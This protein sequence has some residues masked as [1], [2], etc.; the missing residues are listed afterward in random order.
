LDDDLKSLAPFIEALNKVVRD[1]SAY[2]KTS[3]EVDEQFSAELA[4]VINRSKAKTLHQTYSIK[5][6]SQSIV[7]AL[8][9]PKSVNELLLQ[10]AQRCDLSPKEIRLLKDIGLFTTD[11]DNQIIV[12]S[13]DDVLL[14]TSRAGIY[15]FLLGC[16]AG[17]AI[18]SILIEPDAGISL[19]LRGAGLGI[20]IGSIAGFVLGRSSRAYP[21]LAKLESIY[22]WLKANSAPITHA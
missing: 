13:K 19:I 1:P 11:S 17:F 15:L 5:A 22:P 18:A 14:P 3:A 7:R 12:R 2:Q 16:L 20:A 4:D 21:V 10:I 8:H 9:R 6:I